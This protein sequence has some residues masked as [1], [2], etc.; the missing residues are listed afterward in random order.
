MGAIGF[1]TGAFT[2]KS[3]FLALSVAMAMGIILPGTAVAQ[4][5]PADSSD[6]SAA[7]EQAEEPLGEGEIIVTARR[8]AGFPV[9]V[10]DFSRGYTCVLYGQPILIRNPYSTPGQVLFQTE[11][12]V[13][14]GATDTRAIKG[15]KLSAS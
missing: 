1:K 12:R 14:G 9:L 2:D 13:G 11:R 7:T 6:Q 4:T 15:L 5:A 3:S 10:G 8:R